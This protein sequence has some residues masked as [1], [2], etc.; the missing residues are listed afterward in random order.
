MTGKTLYIEANSGISGDMFVAAFLD[1]GADEDVLKKALSSIP[2]DG[3]DIE[4]SRKKRAEIDVCDF[5]VILDHEHEN[6]DHD[7]E[8]LYGH[9]K[10]GSDHHEHFAAHHHEHMHD[11]GAHAHTHHH[12]TLRDVYDIIEK[13]DMTEGAAAIAKSIFEIL[14][15]AEAKAHGTDKDEV[16]FHEVGAVD[17]I[18]DII[19][20]AVCVDDLAPDNV[21]VSP[22]TEGSGTVRTQHGILPVPVPAVANIATENGLILRTGNIRGEL[23]TPTGA[24]IIAAIKTDDMLPAGYLI[25]GVGMGGGKRD[26]DPPSILRAMWIEEKTDENHIVKLET[27][28]DDSTGEELGYVMEKLYGAG[29]RE[30]HFSPIYMKKNRPAYELTVIC[31]PD[32]A[33][34]MERIIFTKTTT[35]GIRRQY[36][37][38]TVLNRRKIS[39]ETACGMIEAKEVKLPG[40]STRVYPEYE[41]MKNAAKENSVSIREVKE[42]FV[43]VQQNQKER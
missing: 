22:L 3:F 38:R 21:I 7:M 24:A 14:A 33:D 18:V 28:I 42:E 41:S 11:E 40:G 10:S 20:A 16:H 19:A 15:A 8:Y 13:T 1:L 29:A 23:V 9:E 2:I 25:K 34:E 36:M 35:I 4:I 12:R 32:Q 43:R 5:N 30:V 6:N 27:D 37:E 17:S 31:M 39:V 26:Y